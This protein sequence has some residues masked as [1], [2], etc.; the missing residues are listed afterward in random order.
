MLYYLVEIYPSSFGKKYRAQM[1]IQENYKRNSLPWMNF[2]FPF[3]ERFQEYKYVVILHDPWTPD[4]DFH[5]KEHHILLHKG[6]ESD[7]NFYLLA[8]KKK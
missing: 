4:W 3:G 8:R 1:M 2:L 7:R 6:R 5:L